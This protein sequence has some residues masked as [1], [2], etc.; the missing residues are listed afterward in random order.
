MLINE[1]PRD[2][3]LIIFSSLSSGLATKDTIQIVRVDETNR[4]FEL[5]KLVNTD[6]QLQNLYSKYQYF[7]MMYENYKNSIKSL[8]EIKA[9]QRLMTKLM[10]HEPG[11]DLIVDTYDTG[12]YDRLKKSLHFGRY[13]DSDAIWMDIL[14][15]IE[16][17]VEKDKDKMVR[18]MIRR[19][20]CCYTKRWGNLGWRYGIGG[21]Q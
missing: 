12:S 2:I 20:K 16:L 18:E 6:S 9:L 11:F 15:D 14:L 3:L 5:N 10:V 19:F 13:N 4:I 1:L 21:S 7:I 8:T 17:H